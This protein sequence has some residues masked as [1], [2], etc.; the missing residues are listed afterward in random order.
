VAGGATTNDLIRI[1]FHNDLTSAPTG[2]SLGNIG[3][4]NFS[5]SLSKLF[6]VGADLYT[7][8]PNAF[9]NT[10]TRVRFPG[11][12]NA[13]FPNSALKDPPVITYS[14]P[15]TYRVNLIMDDGLETEASFCKT[16]VVVP[17]PVITT[18][19]DTLICTG[20][21]V[22]LQ[23]IGAGNYTYSWSPTNGLSDPAISNPLATPAASGYYY[24]TA[25]ESQL[26][27]T[28]RDSVLI[29]LKP[30]DSFGIQSSPSPANVCKGDSI[31]LEAWGG[32]P[33]SRDSWQWLTPIGTQDPSSPSVDV[34]PGGTTTYQVIGFDEI[35]HT[36]D[37]VNLPVNVLPL[38]TIATSKSNDIDCIIGEARLFASGAVRYTWYPTASLSD[39]ASS[40]PLASIDTTTWYYVK[41]KGFNGCTS[42]DSIV[43]YVDKHSPTNGYPVANAFTPN[44]DGHND[45]FGVKY[46][47]YIGKMEMA[48]FNRWG[49]RVFESK[50]Q[51]ACWD[52][53]YRGQ[54]Q[55][56]G[57]YVYIIHAN[58][59]CGNVV[60]K[61]TLELIR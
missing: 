51:D 41:G 44:G 54:P 16:I 38:P 59:L 4:F 31:R 28:T 34:S 50:S 19:N 25:S 3:N 52:G 45:C 56:E 60:R 15:G 6:R 40:S 37:T 14:Q 55:P 1:D 39:S 48:I 7:F 61:G 29:K 36:S 20:G 35:C 32:S 47:G 13:S 46:W 9:N 58:T 43:V 8:V 33:D 23:V 11:C 17:A 21:S 53:T 5:H 27:C 22:Q 42:K 24:V 12:D 57:T 26:T 49:V 18:T 10:L 2:V 30:P